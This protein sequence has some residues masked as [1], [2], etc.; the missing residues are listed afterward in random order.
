[1]TSAFQSNAFQNNA[2]QSG[3]VVNPGFRSLVG[4]QVGGMS[5]PAGSVPGVISFWGRWLGRV[6]VKA[7]KKH[8]GWMPEWRFRHDPAE[9]ER[10]LKAQKESAFGPEWLDRFL[11]AEEAASKRIAEAKTAAHRAALEAAIEQ[12]A[13]R[14]FEAIDA[15]AAAPESLILELEAAASA[16]RATASIKHAEYVAY[17]AAAEDDEEAIFLLL[18]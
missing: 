14:V 2:F 17:L 3:P 9:L 13:A 15:G 8:V 1:M 12:V 6:G 16:H 11:A 10:R 4:R 7:T 18:H 5:A